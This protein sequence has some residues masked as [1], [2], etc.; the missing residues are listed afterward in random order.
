MV[1]KAGI[2]LRGVTTFL[3]SIE[4]LG[5]ALVLGITSYWLG[6]LTHRNAALPTWMKA[7]EGMAGGAVIYT[8]FAVILTCFLGGF[9]F[10]AFLAVLLDILFV[11]AFVAIAILTRG[12]VRSC[13][14]SSPP[15]VLG[16]GNRTSCRLETA[17]FAVALAMA[18]CFLISA[19]LQVL[20]SRQHKRE[21]RYGPGPS[22][23]YT[24]GSGKKQPFW[25]RNRGPKT[26]HEAAEMGAFG[27]SGVGTN[28]TSTSHKKAPF[29]K[30]SKNTPTHD[31]ELGVLG[32]SAI[33]AEEKQ[34]HYHNRH[35]QETGV[36]GTTAHSPGLAYGGPNDRYGNNEQQPTIPPLSHGHAHKQNAELAAEYQPYRSEHA[37][38]QVIHDPSPYADVHHGGHVHVEQPSTFGHGNY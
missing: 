8:G 23:N 32:G 15:S 21:K 22:N 25:K 24:S 12:G 2:A 30:R 18:L 6:V 27:T 34:H 14:G 4:F 5:S 17:V 28:A 16:P 31:A 9:T 7:V 26:T 10:F 19:A 1:T 3:R 38:T 11:G 36:T 13:G 20:L 35:S 29:W 37:N 33:I